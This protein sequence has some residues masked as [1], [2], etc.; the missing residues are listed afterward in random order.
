MR[1]EYSQ[2]QEKV[3]YGEKDIDRL[4]KRKTASFPVRGEGQRGI[5]GLQ[6][7]GG[8]KVCEGRRGLGSFLLGGEGEGVCH[9]GQS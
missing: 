1:K 3:D 8:I 5:S 9:L 4:L 6:I 7:K 2:R